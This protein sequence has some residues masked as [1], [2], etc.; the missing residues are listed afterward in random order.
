MKNKNNKLKFEID[1]SQLKIVFRIFTI[2]MLFVI[3]ALLII[4]LLIPVAIGI[5]NSFVALYKLYLLLTDINFK[6]IGGIFFLCVAWIIF[7]AIAYFTGLLIDV[8][9]SQVNSL[10]NKTK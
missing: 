6:F 8:T 10:F 7:K 1:K 4:K 2:V 9:L 3:I 5:M